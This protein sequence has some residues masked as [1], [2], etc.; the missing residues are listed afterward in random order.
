MKFPLYLCAVS[1]FAAGTTPKPGAAGYPAHAASLGAEY[2]VRSI[3]AGGQS[4]VTAD[5]LVVEVAVYPPKGEQAVVSSGD[6]TLRING[7]KHPIFAQ[8]PGFVAAS[9]KY[10]DWTQRPTLVGTAGVGDVDVVLGRQRRS[11]RFPG[12][13]SQQTRLPNPPRAP[14]ADGRSGQD[15]APSMRPEEAV[16]EYALPEGSSSGAV[17]GYLYFA[18]KGKPKS[19]RSLELIYKGKQGAVTLPLLPSAR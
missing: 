5:Y 19:I 12:D 2:L 18:F 1:L 14:D 16:T 4:F 8:P 3:F 13:G 17:S 15:N 9:L 6:F 10:D 11:E 7:A